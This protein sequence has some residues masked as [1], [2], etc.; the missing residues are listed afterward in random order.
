MKRIAVVSDIHANIY[1]LQKFLNYIHEER[2]ISTI[3]NLGDF[4]Q[5]GPNPKEVFDIIMNDQRFINVLGNNENVLFNRNLMRFE[6]SEIKHQDWV[7][8][9]L[10]NDR[11]EQLKKLDKKKI[12][13]IENKIILMLHSRINSVIEFPLLY[14]HKPLEDFVADYNENVDYVLIGHT[15]FPLY[16][17]HWNWKPILNPGSLGC[18]R[19]G[20]I[21]FIIIEIEGKAV[22]VNYKQLEYDKTNVINDYHKFEV[23][24]RDK[25]I[26][27]FF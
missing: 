7:I 12:I 6:E 5:I 14:E 18:G 26:E 19:D 17:V 9:Q 20:I 2:D 23:P 3:L 21:K 1:A 27:R 15:H 11:I 4:L 25:F 16:A 10:G 24:F 13:E 8:N 22:N